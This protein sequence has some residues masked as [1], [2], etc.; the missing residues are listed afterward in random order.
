M[1][2]PSK[3]K[4]VNKVIKIVWDKELITHDDFYGAC[5]YRYERIKIQ[6]ST[7]SWPRSEQDIEHT[8]FHELTHYILDTMNEGE[9]RSNE[10]FVD[11]FSGILHQVLKDNKIGFNK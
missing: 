7:K 11:V 5:E 1:K 6:P 8:F 9:L 4:I 3:L 10:K 2:I